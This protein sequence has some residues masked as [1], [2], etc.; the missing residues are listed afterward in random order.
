MLL[1]CMTP[2]TFTDALVYGVWTDLKKKTLYNA[3]D[4]AAGLALAVKV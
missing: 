3:P 4:G 2:L 1:F